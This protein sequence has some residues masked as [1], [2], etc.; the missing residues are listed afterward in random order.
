MARRTTNS[1]SESETTTTTTTRGR[2][3]G[4][5]SQGGNSNNS[6]T[7]SSSGKHRTTAAQ[8]AYIKE[9]VRTHITNNHPNLKP[10]PHP[11]DISAYSD[12]FLR[13]YRDRYK[14]DCPDNYTLQGYLLGSTVGSQTVSQGKIQKDRVSRDKLVDV[15]SKHWNSVQYKEAVVIPQ[16]IYKVRN[17]KRQFR[18][19]FRD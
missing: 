2:S 6:N 15:V 18:M 11:T 3:Q 12:Q 7:N 19:E 14:L 13:K 17:K 1:A 8:Q 9:L 16:F 10:Q 4:S 5:G